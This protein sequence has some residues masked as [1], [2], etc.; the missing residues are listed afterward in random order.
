MVAP[1]NIHDGCSTTVVKRLIGHK[2]SMTVKRAKLEK[3]TL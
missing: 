3:G 1:E 2:Q